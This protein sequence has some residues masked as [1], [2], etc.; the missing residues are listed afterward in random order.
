LKQ[1]QDILTS[2]YQELFAYRNKVIL[3]RR[4]F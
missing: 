3:K 1:F 4:T 2:L